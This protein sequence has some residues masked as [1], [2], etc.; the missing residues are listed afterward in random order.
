MNDILLEPSIPA[1]VNAIE[2][3]QYA[4]APL[5]SHL[6][7]AILWD[8]PELLGLLTDLDPSE[9]FVYRT[10]FVADEVEEKI[11]KVLERFRAQSCLPM[12]WQVSPSTTPT[13]LGKYLEAHGFGF[14]IRARGMAVDLEN[15][16]Y[17]Q[18]TEMHFVIEQVMNYTQLRQWARIVGIVDRISNALENGFYEIFKNQGFS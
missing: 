9:S 12:C 1:L 10:H 11:E 6:P 17:R 7:G 18:V 15:L 2:A 13:D 4:Q 8:D 14:L 5:Y 3:N 16:D